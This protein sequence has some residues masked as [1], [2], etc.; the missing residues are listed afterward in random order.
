LCTRADTGKY[1][2]QELV[3]DTSRSRRRPCIAIQQV[4]DV[5]DAASRNLD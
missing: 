1:I 5:L 2:P 3:D 4:I